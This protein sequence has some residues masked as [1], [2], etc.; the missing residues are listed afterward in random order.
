M[1]PKSR[2]PYLS[3][4]D[5]FDIKM[6]LTTMDLSEAIHIN[7]PDIDLM[8]DLMW[9]DIW[10]S[11][12]LKKFVYRIAVYFRREFDYSF[13]QYSEEE[14]DLTH[15]AF[16]FLSKANDK[17]YDKNIYRILGGGCFRHRKPQDRPEYY[18]L[19][20]I[21][22]HPYMRR[23]GILTKVFDEFMNKFGQFR[24]ESPYS[25]EIKSFLE[26]GGST[27]TIKD[28]N[29]SCEY[30]VIKVPR[31]SHEMNQDNDY[32]DHLKNGVPVL[33]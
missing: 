32:F 29:K 1:K 16:L 3:R 18:A 19:Q 4:K 28:E 13:V 7:H 14:D 2:N 22:I 5:E 15:R 11:S 17:Y 9:V 6:P 33:S 27:W 12:K 31:S 10:S 21:W 20:W 23:K 30:L 24:V 26:K 8:I 25:V